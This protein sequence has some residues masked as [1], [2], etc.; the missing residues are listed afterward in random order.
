MKIDPQRLLAFLFPSR[1]VGCG[2]RGVDLC[3]RC[4]STIRPLDST[5]CPRCAGP[6]RFGAIC[7]SCRRY[8]GPMAG[9]RAA[10]SYDGVVRK[11]IH[12]FKYRHRQTLAASLAALVG[13]EFRR[14]PLQ[15]DILVPVPLHPRRLAARGYNQSALLA[16]EL[17]SL[18]GAPVA[19]LLE[20]GRETAAQA[21][22]KASQR[23]TNVR[24]VFRCSG[25][26]E[27][28]GARV[29]GVDDVCTTGATL[30][31][32]ARALREAGCTSGWGIVVARDL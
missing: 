32:C 15:V 12:S 21:G 1:C 17:S 22:L 3:E 2:L 23:R 29:G 27:L 7:P 10:T 31:D 8:D 25:S 28:V 11:A 5:C 30:E 26:A 14:R 9:V 18:T 16:G 19:D 4:F 20:R 6:S 24:G 13:M